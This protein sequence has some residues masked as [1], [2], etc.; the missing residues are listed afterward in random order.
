MGRYSSVQ[1]FADNNAN[2][3]AVDYSQ[4]AGTDAPKLSAPGKVVFRCLAQASLYHPLP[5]NMQRS[6]KLSQSR[7]KKW[8]IPMD[9]WL[10][11]DQVTF[12]F[13]DTLDPEKWNGGKN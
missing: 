9:Q 1:A 4:A 8:T 5:A 2:M 10:A 13:I 11:L 6:S 3:R 7:Q 12:M